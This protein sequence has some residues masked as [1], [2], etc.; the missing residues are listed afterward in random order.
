MTAIRHD[1][2]RAVPVARRRFKPGIHTQLPVLKGREQTRRLLPPSWSAGP[3][4]PGSIER[5]LEISRVPFGK[6]RGQ[7]WNE[8]HPKDPDRA[9]R[10]SPVDPDIAHIAHTIRAARRD[11]PLPLP[12]PGPPS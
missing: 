8:V 7:L 10:Q 3:E 2:K 6:H 1:G 4:P 9:A 12:D 11:R 5:L